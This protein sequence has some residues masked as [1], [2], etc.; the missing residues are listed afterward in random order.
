M[1]DRDRDAAVCK[2]TNA[3]LASSD[4]SNEMILENDTA[5]VRL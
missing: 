1:N 5:L 3:S 4:S 2:V